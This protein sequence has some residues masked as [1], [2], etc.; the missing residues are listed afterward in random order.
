MT[1]SWTVRS[2][3]DEGRGEGKEKRGGEK[4]FFF[5]LKIITESNVQK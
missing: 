1:R 2:K 5:Y 4:K 3:E